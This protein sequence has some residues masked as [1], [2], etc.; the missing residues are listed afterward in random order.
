LVHQ[1]ALLIALPRLDDGEISFDSA[2]Q[3]VGSAVEDFV[4]LTLGDL[5]ADPGG[6]VEAGDSGATGTQALG[7][8]ALRI[9]LYLSAEEANAGPRLVIWRQ[10]RKE[11]E[12]RRNANLE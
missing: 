3:D 8:S 7:Q 5:C 10:R 2:L 6:G 12:S 4:L 11:G 9:E 1:V